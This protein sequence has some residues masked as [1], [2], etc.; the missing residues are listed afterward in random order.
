MSNN[1]QGDR[2]RSLFENSTNDVSIIAPFIKTSALQSLLDAIPRAVTLHCVTRWLPREVAGGV[3]DPEILDLLEERGAFTLTLA[4]KL[5]AKLY[6]AGDRCLAGSSNVTFPGLGNHEGS[7]N[8]EV[9]VETTIDDPGVTK[10]LDEIS[11]S[12]RVATRQMARNARRLAENIT[13]QIQTIDDLELSWFPCSYRPREAFKFY[14]NPPAKTEFIEKANRNLISDLANSNI[15]PGLNEQEFQKAIQSLLAEIPI[16][17]S[18]LSSSED[19]ILTRADSKS[20]LETIAGDEYST[21]DLWRAF[22]KWMTH[23]YQDRII[24]EEITE[25]ALRRAQL[26]KH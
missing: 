6:I 24:E 19:K 26:I 21:D 13:I 9:L 11:R 4:D 16:T 1:S 5:H 8:I 25:I 18:I 23:F 12:E 22:V 10:T 20:Y 17:E 14:L 2:I 7:G 15:Q 3:S